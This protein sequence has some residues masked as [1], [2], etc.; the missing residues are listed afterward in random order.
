[1][2]SKTAPRMKEVAEKAGVSTATV[3]RVLS[4]PERVSTDVRARVM[5]A[6]EALDYTR[7]MAARSLRRSDTGMVLVLV[8]DIGNPFYSKLLKGIDDQARLSGLSLLIG[9]AG[10][11]NTR[12]ADFRHKLDGRRAD[13]IILL[14]GQ[15]PE[16]PRYNG[17]QPMPIVI[18][19]EL[20]EGVELST[21]SVDNRDASRIATRHLLDL[22]HRRIA[23][24]TGPSV[25]SYHDYTTE[26]RLAGYEEEMMS[27]GVRP[28][29]VHT[30]FTMD[31]GREA[32]DLMI[33]DP[34]KFPMPTAIFVTND[35][36]A[37]GAIAGLRAAGL[38]V[39]QDV[40]IIGFDDI[41]VAGFYDPPL[42]TI[43]QPRYEMGQVA[44][45]LLEERLRDPHGPV[46]HVSLP[47]TLIVRNSTRQVGM[48]R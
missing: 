46:R 2:T 1:M 18:A 19:S 41:E 5:S 38:R 15:L 7:N 33:S 29:L 25:M 12:L 17:S 22:G 16:F 35:E 44:M 21:V 27:A 23:H 37:V 30:K 13:G 20:I 48:E 6:I 8:P 28:M 32:I 40:S 14:N 43:G 10:P 11:A 42:T 45:Q 9:D 26:E 3:S 31:G 24:I 34:R 4:T 39:P 47:T 36:M